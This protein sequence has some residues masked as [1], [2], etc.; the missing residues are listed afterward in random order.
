MEERRTL[1][2]AELHQTII[3]DSQRSCSS[4]GYGSLRKAQ[5]ASIAARYGPLRIVQDPIKKLVQQVEDSKP[6]RKA[7]EDD[8]SAKSC[9]A[10]HRAVTHADDT[11]RFD[12][13]VK[14]LKTIWGLSYDAIRSDQATAGG[15]E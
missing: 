15:K 10:R 1:I 5:Y 14:A 4:C 7:F 13:K 3:Q 9:G 11:E 12:N 8:L 6:A 2:K